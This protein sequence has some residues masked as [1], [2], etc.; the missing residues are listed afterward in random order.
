MQSESDHNYFSLLK[1]SIEQTFYPEI[2]TFG[3]RKFTPRL[4]FQRNQT[5]LF[6][7]GKA[8]LVHQGP[9]SASLWAPLP[10]PAAGEPPRGG[11]SV[12]LR[13]AGPREEV[14]EG[15]KAG[16]EAQ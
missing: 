14:P 5:C 9:R 1:C 7:P 15:E 6:L 13:R 8:A 11:V 4:L 12:L 3:N 16:G 10:A 2:K